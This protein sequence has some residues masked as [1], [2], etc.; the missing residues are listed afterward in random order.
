MESKHK[1]VDILGVDVTAINMQQTIDTIDEWIRT[2]HNKYICVVPAHSI[3]LGYQNLQLREIFNHSGLTTPDGMVIVWLLRLH[4]YRNVDRV[5]GPDL[6]HAVC[7]HSLQTGWKHYFFGGEPGVADQLSE[8]LKTQYPELQISGTYS[9]PFRQLTQDED[10]EIITNI[11]HAHPDIVW[12]GLGSP[13]QEYWMYEHLEKLS[14]PVLIGVGAAFDFLSG[15]KHQ[16]PRWIQR[17]GFEWLFRLVNEP[18]RLW[19]RYA[20]YPLFIFL[21]LLQLFHLKKFSNHN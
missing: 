17:S 20:N 13:K 16:A 12:V 8:K 2:N 5:Y 3:F 7:K 21:I 1:H 18:R 19:R 4:G 15:N 9:P 14:A 6:M 10:N 11:N